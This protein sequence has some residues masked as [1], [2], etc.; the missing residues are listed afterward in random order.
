MLFLYEGL[1]SPDLH[2]LLLCAISLFPTT[3]LKLGLFRP[4]PLPL[5]F[6]N[7]LP[8]ILFL[9]SRCRSLLTQHEEVLFVAQ[10]HETFAGGVIGQHRVILGSLFNWEP[11]RLQITRLELLR[12]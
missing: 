3:G 9:R 1:R 2:I 10:R 8:L 4:F 7:F 12:S 6:L 5:S 11:E